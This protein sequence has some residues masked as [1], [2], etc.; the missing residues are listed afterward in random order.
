MSVDMFEFPVLEDTRP[1]DRSL[2]AF[3]VSTTRGFLPRQ[4]PLE[5]LPVEFEAVESLLQRMP[6][7]TLSGEPGLLAKFTFGDTLDKELPDLSDEV[8]KYR[9]DLVVMNALYRDYSFLA[10]AYLFEP[11]HERFLKDEPYGLGRQKL[12]RSIALP[13]VKVA[14]IAGFKPFMEYAG[15]Y[16]L[17]N[18]RLQDPDK[19]LEYDNLRLI[20]AFEHGLDPSSSEAG[21]VLVHI[22]MVKESGPLVKGT[23]EMLESCIAKDRERF[24]D[25]LRTVVDGLKNVNAVMNT[26]WNRSKPQS[27][28]HFRTFIF[29]ITSQSMFPNG[30]IY[31]G[32]SEE[33]MSFRGESGANDSMIPLCDNL[34]QIK[35]PS[36]PLT[37]ILQ[38][39]RQYR[40]GN[41]RE[42]LEAVRG[43]AEAS[44]VRDFALSSPISAALYLQALNEVRD[45]RWRHWCF[46]REYIL[47]RTM[48]PTATGGS[49]IVT[50][51]PNQLQAVLEQM[52]DTAAY[53][54]GVHGV[55]DIMETA[56]SQRETLKKEVA[57]YCGERG[58]TGEYDTR[59]PE[60]SR[61][62]AAA[63]ADDHSMASRHAPKQ[64]PIDRRKG[65]SALSDFADY[66]QKQQALRRP[67]GQT[68]ADLEEHDELSILDELGLSDDAT[69]AL[70]LK[71][72]L[73]DPADGNVDKL[74]EYIEGR[75]AEG[76]GEALFDLGLE[77][78]GDSMAFSVTDWES[79]LARVGAACDQTKA[80]Y[81][82]LMTRNVGADP[83]LEV[84][85]RD[86]KDTGASGK[87]ILRRRPESVDDVIE[88]RIA[89]VGNVDAGKSTMLG[90]LVK[91]GLDDGRGKAR[92]NLFRHKH[93]IESGRTSSVGMEIM[94]FDSKGD[95]VVSNVAGRKLTWEEIG[96]RSAKVIGFTDLA[97][98]EKYLRTTVFGLLSSEPNYCLLMVAANNGLVGM[99]KEHLGIALAL[100]VPVMVVITKIDICPPQILEQTIT[101][102][103]KI[104]KS[105]GARKI[106]IFIKNREECINTATQFVSRRICPIFQVSNVTGYNL[107]LVRTFL[108]ILP[109][110]GNYNSSAPLEFHVND[111]FSVPFVGTVVS[112]VVKSGV[113]HTGDTILIGPDSLGQFTTTKVRSIERKRIQVPGCSA[114]QS[115][116]LALR[117]VRRKDVRKGMVVLHK[118]DPA[119]GAELTPKVFREFVAEVLILSH[120]TTIKTKYQAMLH[121]GPVSQTCAIIDI[122][123][124]YIRT[125][126][127][128]QVAFRFV[129]RPEYLTVGDRILFRE[130]RTK[131]L[132]IVKRVGYDP[133]QPLNP[134]ALK[135]EKKSEGG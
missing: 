126:D 100:N 37:E 46:T 36:T 21:F 91:G 31:E 118:N 86:A 125:G 122:D 113:I 132:G 99:S 117:N 38:D 63:A 75:L 88:T 7:K 116:S 105:P 8:E 77:D 49:P 112:G 33:P 27:Y 76:H 80:D 134:E 28:T 127:R 114:G 9:D 98:H 81:K 89:V 20:R 64:S 61:H 128:A 18:Y 121:V 93:E 34:L 23:V 94:G 129:Q 103:T 71:T 92:V 4:E 84:G 70:P 108:N 85:P 16:A 10:S 120:A 26:M 48:H 102:L 90:V 22:A 82:L 68:P 106:P 40:P 14:E 19:G 107:D 130:G 43:C 123:R 67:P 6:I 110:H 11:C 15:S 5:R 97:G 56:C 51:L 131:G 78:S 135:E 62:T 59:P 54:K 73:L 83:E 111:T 24:D 30:V 55:D 109:H 39:F 133:K 79:A 119:T 124:N 42:F 69:P 41:H 13:I 60:G 25:G 52:V 3:M 47:K 44:G 66:V 95:V 104:L 57:K 101:Q 2:P 74:A 115:A 50:W 53:C 17:F 35:M 32:V 29:G 12:P 1:K 58:H 87:L 45:F 72:L 65:E 96:R